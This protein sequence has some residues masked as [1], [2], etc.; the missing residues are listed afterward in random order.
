[1]KKYFIPIVFF[2]LLLTTGYAQ[3]WGLGGGIVVASYQGDLD[4][5]LVNTSLRSSRLGVML[6]LRNQMSNNFAVKGNLILS[7]LS[8]TDKNF[9]EPAWRQDR[10]INFK[11]PLIELSAQLEYYPFGFLKY[12]KS[13]KMESSMKMS[14]NQKYKVKSNGDTVYIQ[15]SRR[16]FYPYILIG[17][18]G[19][20]TKPKVD[21]NFDANNQNAVADETLIAEDQDAK[22]SPKFVVPMGG[23]VRIPFNT[24]TDIGI[25]AALRPTFNDYLEGVSKSANPDDN[26]W[27]FIGSVTISRSIG[28]GDRDGDGICNDEDA[29]PELAGPKSTKGCPDADNDGVIDTNDKCPMDPGPKN[30]MGC[31]DSDGDMVIDKDDLC[32]DEKGLAG[33]NGCPDSDKD[34]IINSNDECPNEFGLKEFNGCP[35]SDNDGIRDKDDKCPTVKGVASNAGCPIT[36]D[37]DKD[38]ISDENDLCPDMPGELKWSGCPDTDNDGLPDNKDDCPG[39]YGPTQFRGCP[40]TDGDGV[41]DNLDKCPNIAG[42]KSLGGCPESN[43]KTVITGEIVDKTIYFDTRLYDWQAESKLRLEEAVQIMKNNPN[44]QAII[45]GHTDNT[46]EQ[47]ANQLLSERRARK[48]FDYLASRGVEKSRMSFSGFADKKPIMPNNTAENRQ[49][50]RRVEIH[51]E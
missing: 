11:S 39:I 34:G 38:G 44:L 1:M 10:G 51:F 48:A 19:A 21:W 37:R 20:Y 16:K 15:S 31:P 26:D 5:Y 28:C 8:G 35:D 41:Q 49:L 25:E 9:T 24:R 32:P 42:L 45:T 17:V 47:P 43:T 46:G 50:N 7:G 40:D 27:Y 14:E 23:G 2:S 29:C 4:K 13:G 18:G 22:V 33:M 3:K 6:N 30:T 36:N 12:K